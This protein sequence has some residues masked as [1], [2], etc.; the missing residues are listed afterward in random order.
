MALSLLPDT[1]LIP[2]GEAVTRNSRKEHLGKRRPMPTQP[3]V[4]KMR[5]ARAVNDDALIGGENS[6]TR[7]SDM[8]GIKSKVPREARLP[9]T[10]T[11]EEHETSSPRLARGE[12]NGRQ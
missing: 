10:Q 6:A 3:V 12:S 5:I 11:I 4:P 9:D 8:K 7:N 1:S 2:P